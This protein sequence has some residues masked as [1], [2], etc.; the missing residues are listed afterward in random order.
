MRQTSANSIYEQVTARI[1]SALENGVI[2]WQK[3]WRAVD[4]PVNAVSKREYRGINVLILNLTAIE[5]GYAST[6]W[7]TYSAAREHGG[8]VRQGEKATSVVWWDKRPKH[9]HDLDRDD[10][11]TQ[12]APDPSDYVFFARTCSVFCLDQC[13]GLELLRRDLAGVQAACEPLPACQRVIAESGVHVRHGGSEAFYSPLTDSITLPAAD[14][15]KSLDGYYAT[16]FHELMH[17][18]GA[19][20]RLHRDFGKRFGDDQYAIEELVAELGAAFLSSMC[21]IEHLTQAASYIESWLSVLKQ[22]TRAIFTAA[23]SATVAADYL[24][25]GD[26]VESSIELPV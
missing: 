21:G 9:R 23:R 15:F 25:R 24:A 4:G 26:R 22:D 19:P 13:D 10:T 7:I 11:R 6:G 16:A 20:H 1:V 14:H 3:P 8:H 2:P 12:F 17:A 18:T 5:R